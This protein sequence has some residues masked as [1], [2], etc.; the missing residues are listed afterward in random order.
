MIVGLTGGIATGKSTVADILRNI[1]ATVIDADQVSR[2]VVQP[3]S[4]GLASLV[5]AFG[6]SILTTEGHLDRS[7]LR[8]I[9]MSNT[10][11]RRRLEAITHPL[12]RAE[13][14]TRVQ[15][16]VVEGAPSVFVEAALLVETGSAQMYPH[17]WV[18]TCAPETQLSRL[19]AR[20]Q[21]DEATAH[22]WIA[23][24]MPLSEKVKHATQVVTNE[25]DQDALRL[26][27]S[28]AYSV[29]MAQLP[30]RG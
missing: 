4:A 19:M 24:Q 26:Q 20:E 8:E 13:I 23:A 7:K 14:A 27:V 28:A 21:C 1:G 18:V 2:D 11:L 17:L 30:G 5:E 29:L 12:I 9:V 25:G 10:V 3:G 15:T 16:A 22:S 6:T